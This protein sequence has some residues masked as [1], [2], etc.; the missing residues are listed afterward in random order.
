MEA[1]QTRVRQGAATWADVLAEAQTN[2]D[3]GQVR[4]LLLLA[5]LKLK[6]PGTREARW[7]RDA[8]HAAA[9]R[10]KAQSAAGRNK[11]QSFASGIGVGFF[12]VVCATLAHV[13][14]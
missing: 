13:Y 10:N 1:L 5:E 11:A 12:V 7:R 3:L 6:P 8:V 4:S 14:V 9:G 2:P